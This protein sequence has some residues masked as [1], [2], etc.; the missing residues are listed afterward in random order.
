MKRIRNLSS[1][2]KRRRCVSCEMTG[3]IKEALPVKLTVAF[4]AEGT[5]QDGIQC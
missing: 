2:E 3:D 4:V 5:P 1:G